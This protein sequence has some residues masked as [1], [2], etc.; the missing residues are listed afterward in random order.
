MAGNNILVLLAGLVL[1]SINPAEAG[2]AGKV[3]RIGV[4][5]P[6]LPTSDV[7]LS[8]LKAF[9][10]G[11]REL[12]YTEG[13]GVALEYRYADG[14][15]RR[16]PKLAADLVRLDVDVIVTTA[17][18]PALAVKQATSKIPI[19][20][21]QVANP[22]E[23]GLVESL[24]RPGGNLTGLSQIGPE[25][26]GKR[27]ELLRDAFPRISRV[28]VL[29]TLRSRGSTVRYKETEIAAESMDIQLQPLEVRTPEDLPGAFSAAKTGRAEGLIILQ[30]ALINSNRRQ[31]VEL[32]AKGR[33]PTM[34]AESTHVESGGLMSYVPSY[35][36][37]QRRAATYVDKILKGRKPAD[38]PVEQPTEFE[39]VINLKTAKQID[40]TIPP[41]V[42]VRAGRVI[43]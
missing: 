43:R 42:L 40:V 13:D 10:Q 6:W 31:I 19:V 27:L 7:S 38:L 18:R 36:D 37:L 11:L 28:A 29:G 26:A 30:S 16:F 14:V 23:E 39:F 33:L 12:G 24:A 5:L 15:S 32:A 34:F 9:R 8:F 21:T 25:L 1:L 35:F 20:F 41:N 22:V 3:S 2:H 17:G 4:L